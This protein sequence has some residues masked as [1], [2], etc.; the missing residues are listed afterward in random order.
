MPALELTAHGP[1]NLLS[2]APARS[3]L[4]E[5]LKSLRLRARRFLP[6]Q[7]GRSACNQGKRTPPPRRRRGRR[8]DMPALRRLRLLDC[9]VPLAL[10]LGRLLALT[11]LTELSVCDPP[12]AASSSAFLEQVG[13][14]THP[15]VL[16]LRVLNLNTKPGP[17]DANAT[18]HGRCTACRPCAPWMLTGQEA[19]VSVAV[20]VDAVQKLG[21]LEKLD[22][23]GRTWESD[24]MHLGQLVGLVQ[25]RPPT[26]LGCEIIVF[27]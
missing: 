3:A 11:G 13:G 5:T 15:Q 10:L 23:P 9:S 17:A 2:P 14:L 26:A 16:K 4:Q 22:M 19:V 7:M 24:A 6:S 8:V 21:G 25:G 12:A 27:S 18:L 20:V 1:R